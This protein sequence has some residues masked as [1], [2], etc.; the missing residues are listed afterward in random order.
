[1]L[2]PTP[3]LLVVLL[4]LAA[5]LIDAQ[6]T[7]P[8]TASPNYK[9][10]KHGKDDPTCSPLVSDAEVSYIRDSHGRFKL[11]NQKHPELKKSRARFTTVTVTT[12]P[13]RT[14][15]TLLDPTPPIK[16][17]EMEMEDTGDQKI[18]REE[19]SVH[20]DYFSRGSGAQP[21]KKRSFLPYPLSSPPMG[22]FNFQ[23]SD[24]DQDSVIPQF[25]VK[26]ADDNE[27]DDIVLNSV[28]PQNIAPTSSPIYNDVG[29]G[30]ES[31]MGNAKW[32]GFSSWGRPWRRTSSSDDITTTAKHIDDEGEAKLFRGWATKRQFSRETNNF[33]LP[34]S[35]SSFLPFPPSP[36][37]PALLIS[38]SAPVDI[39]PGSTSVGDVVGGTSVNESTGNAKWGGF[40]N[41]GRPWRRSAS[42]STNDD[43]SKRANDDHDEEEQRYTTESTAGGRGA[44]PIKRDN[45]NESERGWWGFQAS[46]PSPAP[47]PASAPPSEIVT[48]PTTDAPS[49]DTVGE[50]TGNAKWRNWGRPWKRTSQDDQVD[51]EGNEKW[52]GRGSGAPPF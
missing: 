52:M 32:G 18:T 9:E 34:F 8:K 21:Y 47:E 27:D 20:P 22:Y 17:E 14:V 13:T 37:P 45:G 15:P 1:M 7:E 40:R 26:A 10:C 16:K 28:P 12:T 19:E 44:P 2:L 23:S 42:I 11:L 24:V 50:D 31:S 39:V 3:T 25:T 38:P 49:T 33:V 51:Q 43:D 41:W 35:F 4:S 30:G 6:S 36:A 29:E 48:P 46:A 5:P